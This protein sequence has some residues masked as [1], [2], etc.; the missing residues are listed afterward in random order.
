MI[1]LE[2][3]SPAPPVAEYRPPAPIVVEA[4]PSV[5]GAAVG[6]RQNPYVEA[7]KVSGAVSGAVEGTVEAS[8]PA[9]EETP[10]PP[11]PL[12]QPGTDYVRAVLSGALS[13]RPIT[14]QELFT[15][16][17]T[18]WVPPESEYRLADKTA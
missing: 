14:A 8:A 12:E 18:G 5:D 2:P 10:A 3:V 9:R 7:A 15:R 17:G 11:M 4:A 6:P 13:P 1:A 16:T